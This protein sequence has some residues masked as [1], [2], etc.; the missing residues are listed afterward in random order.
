MTVH[1]FNRTHELD[2]R[3]GDR[4]GESRREA[5]AGRRAVSAASAVRDRGA[6]GGALFAGHSLV[7]E[8]RELRSR[9]A[10][11][12]EARRSRARTWSGCASCWRAS[13]IAPRRWSTRCCPDT[14]AT[15]V[16]RRASFR[17]AEIAGRASSWRKD[18]TRLHVDSF[19]AT[20]VHGQRILRVF[21]NVNPVGPAARLARRRRLRGRGE[22]V[23]ARLSLPW[24]GSAALLRALRVTKS[25]RSAYDALM[26]QLHDRMKA[27]AEFQERSP[28]TA[29]DFPAGTT[30]MAFTDQVPCGDGGPVS[31]RADV[32][33]ARVER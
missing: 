24:P 6:R 1:L 26:L 32:S 11:A 13:A 31:A 19:P 33:A 9:V 28:Q 18:D 30:W 12:W 21:S 2:R 7:G 4:R 22:P 29:F 3:L 5:R 27:D 23:L 17:P 20:P 8:K 15:S 14:A 25:R 16:G 10:A